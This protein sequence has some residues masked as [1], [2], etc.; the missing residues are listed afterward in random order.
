MAS[1]SPLY[2][3]TQAMLKLH[4]PSKNG[5][6]KT[7][8]PVTVGFPGLSALLLHQTINILHFSVIAITISRLTIHYSTL[9]YIC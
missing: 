1:N 5:Y 9:F 7:D 6:L 4:P 8:Y 3:Q 2:Q